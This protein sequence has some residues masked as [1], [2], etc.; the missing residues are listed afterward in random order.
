MQWSMFFLYEF[1]FV[2]LYG[3]ELHKLQ[4]IRLE[5]SFTFFKINLFILLF[6]YFWLRWVFVAMCGLSLVAA[7][8]GYSSLWCV[9]F[10]LQWLLLL[11]STGSRCAGFSSCG[12][13]AQQLWLVGF[14]AQA[15]QLWRTGLVALQHV[16]SSQ[17]RDR[18][19]VPCIGRRILNHC[20]TR[21]VPSFTL[22][23][24]Q[25]FTISVV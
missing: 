12:T 8:G 5:R 4:F 16:A 9:G 18:T 11:Q 25:T 7:S 3:K 17:T 14:R 2:H 22:L 15:Q 20:T 23:K 21:E 6:V 1:L 10:S 13:W 19:H 24:N